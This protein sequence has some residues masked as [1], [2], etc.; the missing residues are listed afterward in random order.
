MDGGR[1][2]AGLGG[3]RRGGQA[4]KRLRMGVPPRPRVTVVIMAKAPEAGRVKARLCPPLSPREAAE[5]SRCFL[6]DP[7]ERVREVPAAVTVI[8]PAPPESHYVFQ[9]L[10]SDGGD[11]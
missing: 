10:A 4:A 5:L 3:D 6:L 2:A 7:I 9:A 1:D 11:G 8:A